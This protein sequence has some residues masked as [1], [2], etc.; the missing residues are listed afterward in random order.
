M[1]VPKITLWRKEAGRTPRLL[2]CRSNDAVLDKEVIDAL[3][4][5]LG[6]QWWRRRM[7]LTAQIATQSPEAITLKQQVKSSFRLAGLNWV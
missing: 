3:A 6:V 1:S 5:F 2:F 4:I 7:Q